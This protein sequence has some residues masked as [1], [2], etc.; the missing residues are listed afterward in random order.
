MTGKNITSANWLVYMILCNDSTL[1]TGITTDMARRWHQHKNQTGAKYFR[2]RAPE[3]L[4][5]LEFSDGRS[6]A[7]QREA[8][9]KKLSRT[10]KL[11]LIKSTKNQVEQYDLA[12]LTNNINQLT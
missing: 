11:E 3:Q 8:S 1:Y 6:S 4:V 2:G 12:I 10:K 7:S 9:L 5:Y